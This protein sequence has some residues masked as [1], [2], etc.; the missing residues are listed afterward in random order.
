MPDPGL[1]TSE[2]P[3]GDPRAA[4]TNVMNSKMMNK[5]KHNAMKQ[6]PTCLLLLLV[7]LTA[8]T[9]RYDAMRAALDS[10]N[11]LNRTDKPF[12][13]DDVQPYV[14]YFDRHGNSNDRLLA[15]YLLGRAYHEHGE[16][17]MA[18]QCYQQAAD[19]ADTTA[20]DCDYAQLCRVYGQMGEIFYDQSLFRH[21][22]THFQLA[23]RFAWLGKDTLSAITYYDLQN[24]AY[25]KLGLP[26]SVMIVVERAVQLY[27]HYGK[28]Q[29]AATAL[30]SLVF[31]AVEKGNLKKARKY[32]SLYESSSGFFNPNGNIETGREIFYYAKGLLY[33]KENRLDSA[34]Y[35]F[36]KELRDG[37]DYN[38]QNGGALGL[39]MLYE[40][41]H[42]PDSAAKY[43]Q[44]AYAMNDSM[45][46]QKATE[47][48][49]RMQSMYDYS[50]HQELAR[51][52]EKQAAR[53]RS[54]WQWGGCIAAII[55][56]IVL[57]VLYRIRAE[58][59]KALQQYEQSIEKLKLIE[60]EIVSARKDILILSTHK[61][62][63]QEI[64]EEKENRIRF[65]EAESQR[66]QQES[67]QKLDEKRLSLAEESLK[68]QVE[69]MELVSEMNRG[70]SITDSQKEKLE[71]ILR[72]HFP[73]TFELI[74]TKR[75]S[76]SEDEYLTCMLIRL[77]I[78]PTQ[79]GLLIEKTGG[80]ITNI[81]VRLL[82]KLFGKQGKA[83]EFDK[84]ICSIC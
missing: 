46:A 25:S 56:L 66:Q 77:H 70:T 79:I 75:H 60:G 29:Y 3:D 47:T 38:N 55:I 68:K 45:Y 51:K 39:A 69:Y 52:A 74:T 19:C 20:A 63:A 61:N 27:M 7:V 1:T 8:C 82:K 21:Y 30:G 65:L 35:L 24:F 32:I 59:Q 83:I 76:L 48:I 44:Y 84:S 81:R 73:K 23:E 16:A 62:A 41:L 64:I 4:R 2:L 12:T 43:Y 26:D 71:T 13:T 9:G 42:I 78:P 11:V 28:P 67:Q 53:E 31:L 58:R 50:R 40:Q 80:S 33:I 14:D 37:K 5:E 36:R 17:P 54:I 34:E 72:I 57:H 49:E 6:L 22:L 10:I 15:H 18:L